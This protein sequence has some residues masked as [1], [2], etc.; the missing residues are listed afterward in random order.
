MN[1]RDE[2]TLAKITVDR[3]SPVPMY[4]QI[5]MDLRQRICRGEWRIGSRLPPEP[6]L[7]SEYDVSRMTL[8]QALAHL[9]KEDIIRRQRGSGTFINQ[10][11]NRVV[12]TLG[13]P[14]SLT[15]LIR[16][17]GVT[18]SVSVIHAEVTRPPSAEIADS[19]GLAE[20]DE[21]ASYRRVFSA[22]GR[23]VALSTSFLPH[24][25]CQGITAV[26]LVDGSLA[27]TLSQR[28]GLTPTQVDQ[29]TG[30]APA[31]GELAKLLKVKPQS[32]LLSITNVLCLADGTPVEYAMTYCVGD[33][34][35]LHIHAISRQQNDPASVMME[36][37]TV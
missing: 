28:Y 15:N 5:A 32:S 29:F 10:Y 11:P 19:L 8:R 37:I 35:R 16:S 14:M 31:S 36:T 27:M 34:L 2:G 23:P 33:R 12:P 1:A 24:Q 26:P 21:V 17:L 18:A 4:Y 6:E 9:E 20:D 13:F 25:L 22:G 7:A 3:S 30:A